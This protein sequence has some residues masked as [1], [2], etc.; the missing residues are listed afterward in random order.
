MP[1]PECRPGAAVIAFVYSQP[2]ARVL[3]CT[4]RAYGIA[5][6][7]F[8]EGTISANPNWMT[9]LGGIRVFVPGVQRD[10]AIAL[11]YEIDEGW[12]CPPPPYARQALISIALTI[13]LGFV[14]PAAA[15]PPRIRGH[16]AWRRRQSDSGSSER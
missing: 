3:V 10:E 15:P 6:F 13:L 1:E 7:A 8:D 9:A 14:V 2:E 4:L 11:L 12:T 5:A 16:Y